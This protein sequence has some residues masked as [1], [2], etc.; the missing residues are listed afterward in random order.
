MH[1]IAMGFHVPLGYPTRQGVV[2]RKLNRLVPADVF[3]VD[4]VADDLGVS[5]F[6]AAHLVAILEKFFQQRDAVV[7][8][9]AD[10]LFREIL[11]NIDRTEL[12]LPT[13]AVAFVD[14]GADNEFHWMSPC[15]LCTLC[16][17]NPSLG[18]PNCADD[19][20][21]TDENERPLELGLGDLPADVLLGHC[22]ADVG[23]QYTHEDPYQF[24]SHAHALL[25]RSDSLRS[26]C[27]R[28]LIRRQHW[29]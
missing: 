20:S 10:V 25:R 19:D 23:N 11:H 16:N 12:G 9:V 27:L 3:H 1:P 2:V 5:D 28:S 8:D 6:F 7:F 21:E 15:L 14:L 24:P 18:Q 4:R 13:F 22:D 17:G 26:M 29:R